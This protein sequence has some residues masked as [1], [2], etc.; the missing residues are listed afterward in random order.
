[1]KVD[2]RHSG[3][4]FL[5]FPDYFS[6]PASRRYRQQ[7][8]WLLVTSLLIF[9]T[10]TDFFSG[11]VGR[12]GTGPS[13]SAMIASI[14]ENQQCGIDPRRAVFLFEP[15]DLNRADPVTLASLR[16]IGPR[17]AE[18]IVAYRQ[19]NGYFSGPAA[20]L[21]V[22]GIGAQKLARIRADLTT[23]SCQE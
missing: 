19:A 20:L 10:G 23:V 21:N 14:G 4:R 8:A 13:I 3:E 12:D 22:K 15:I 2:R 7:T 5:I 1:M 17:I 18:R 16:G 6:A 9:L 11:G